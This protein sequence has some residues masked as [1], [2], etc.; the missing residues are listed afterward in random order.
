MSNSAR[1]GLWITCDWLSLECQ[2]VSA[3]TQKVQQPKDTFK[4]FSRKYKVQV[5]FSTMAGNV[6]LLNLA[7]D[8]CAAGRRPCSNRSVSPARR[9]HISKPTTWDRQQT[10]RWAS[11]SYTDPVPHTTPSVKN[12]WK[13]M[14]NRV[15]GGKWPAW[16]PPRWWCGRPPPSDTDM[17][18]GRWTL[19]FDGDRLTTFPPSSSPAF[20]S[21]WTQ[22]I[23]PFARHE[24]DAGFVGLNCESVDNQTAC[25]SSPCLNG[26]RCRLVGSVVNFTCDCAAGYQ[27]NLFLPEC[28]FTSVTMVTLIQYPS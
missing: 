4:R 11:D 13:S 14:D 15:G 27:G 5:R 6:T 18:L 7:V 9:A 10:D 12:G 2:T 22:H 24:L 20:S 8:R 16:S 28:L 1:K 23:S 17:G 19:D 26:G 25:C 3:E 21:F